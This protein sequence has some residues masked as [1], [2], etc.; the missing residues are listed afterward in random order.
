VNVYN[1]STALHLTSLF[2]LSDCVSVFIVVCFSFFLFSQEGDPFLALKKPINKM[3][4]FFQTVKIMTIPA[5][6]R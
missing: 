5:N 2:I 1:V 4:F 3:I 6:H